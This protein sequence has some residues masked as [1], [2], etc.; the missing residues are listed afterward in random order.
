MC[1]NIEA[2]FDSQQEQGMT[3]GVGSHYVSLGLS[4]HSPSG[5]YPYLMILGPVSFLVIPNIIFPSLIYTLSSR[6]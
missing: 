1:E 4:T 5:A 3:W 2:D 6:V